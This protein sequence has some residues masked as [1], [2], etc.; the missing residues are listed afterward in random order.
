MSLIEIC[1]L[2]ITVASVLTCLFVYCFYKEFAQRFYDSLAALRA[3]H[4]SDLVDIEFI[5]RDILRDIRDK[6]R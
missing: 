4:D 1:L 2:I 5:L 6:S 3:I